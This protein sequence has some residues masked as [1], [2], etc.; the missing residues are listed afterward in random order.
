[1]PDVPVVLHVGWPKTATTS[2]QSQ[3]RGYPNLAGKPYGREGAME[4]RL[5]VDALVRSGPWHHDG[6]RA[7]VEAAYRDATLPVILSNESLIE[8]PQR[9]WFDNCVGPFDV[10]RRLAQL[11]G[12]HHVFMTLR[13][14]REMLRSTWLHH[15]REGRVQGYADFLRRVTADRTAGRGSFAIRELVDSYG[16]IFGSSRVVVAFS[17]DFTADP[18]RFWQRFASTFGCEG[19][20]VDAADG[21]PRLNETTLGPVAFEATVN[22]LLNLYA[23]VARTENTRHLRRW[24][25]R[26]VSVRI[27]SDHRRFFAR[28]AAIEDPLVAALAIDVSYV[29]GM[30]T[31]L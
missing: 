13:D 14:P 30:Y 22:R 16:D 6:L 29:R 7:L 20:T 24:V 21:V 11:E 28:F 18:A 19:F 1:V 23:K 4:A 2:L 10:A 5:V 25:T 8:M 26:H 17:E 27:H 12:Q 3:F 9:E 31:V 15:V